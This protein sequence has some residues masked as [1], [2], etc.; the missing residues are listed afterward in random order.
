MIGKH[1]GTGPPLLFGGTGSHFVAASGRQ[2]LFLCLMHS[3]L[4]LPEQPELELDSTRPLT[5]Q[6]TMQSHSARIFLSSTF[7]DFH[8][9]RRLLVQEVFLALRERL[10]SRFVELVDVDLRWG[11]P[12]E[13]AESG[14]VLGICLDEVDQC[15]PYFIGLLGER[16]G[17]VPTTDKYPSYILESHPWLSEH[18][19]LASVTELEIRYGVLNNP[20]MR[21]RALFFFRDPAYAQSRGGEFL[22][23]SDEDADRQAYLK[24]QIKDS[25]LPVL[26]Y[27]TPEQLARMLEAELWKL[28]DA[29]F[30]ASD[31]PDAQELETLRHR[32][33]AA[34]KVGPKFVQDPALSRLLPDALAQGHQRILIT[35]AVGSGKSTL[36]ADWLRCAEED[37][38]GKNI[39]FH[40]VEADDESAT[41]ADLIGRIIELIR[42]RTGSVDPVPQDRSTLMKSLSIWLATAHAFAERTKSRWIIMLDALDGLR[43][44]RDLLWLPTFLPSTVQL[45]VSSRPGTLR[46]T[47]KRRG[48]WK[49]IQIEPLSR[50]RQKAMLAGQLA[51]FKKRLGEEQI[52]V[53]LAHPCADQ[54]L[55]L[56]VLAEELR[57]FGS[58]EGLQDHLNDLVSSPGIDDLYERIL[59]RLE[60]NGLDR[61]RLALSGICLSRGGMTEAEVLGF[62]GLAVQARWAPIRLA[63]GDALSNASGRV[64]P[65]HAHLRKAV[66]DRYYP[67]EQSERALRLELAS[68]FGQRPDSAIRASEQTHQLWKAAAYSDLLGQLSDPA[69]FK[70]V[71]RL[72][73]SSKLHQYWADIEANLEVSAKEHYQ[74]LWSQWRAELSLEKRLDLSERLQRFFRF[75][76][77]AGE[78][79]AQLAH[80][81]LRD[82]QD[83]YGSSDPLYLKHLGGCANTLAMYKNELENA[84][85]LAEQAC[86]AIE[87][88]AGSEAPELPPQLLDLAMICLKQR[89]IQPGIVAVRR[90]LLL[91]EALTDKDHPSLVEYLNCL[92]DLLLKGAGRARPGD[93]GRLKGGME[94]L[95]GIEL[96]TRCLRILG[97]TLG[98]EHLDSAASLVRVGHVFTRCLSV[99]HATRAYKRAQEIRVRLLGDRHPL[100]RSAARLL[101]R[102]S[103]I[104]GVNSA[105]DAL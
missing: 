37:Q 14:R 79:P 21:Q 74:S 31:V 75:R 20:A 102:S 94:L 97:R 34:F 3:A 76:A 69:I 53:A 35:G 26:H 58:F 5:R 88:V 22:P 11:I 33:Y 98:L 29:E 92:T 2:L 8:D 73:G 56:S 42:R 15:R 49:Y 40:F 7:R 96:Q 99:D 84:R 64:R 25:G 86:S 82:C 89:D 44:G 19:G 85:R 30:P 72:G 9:E 90:G 10:R 50:E 63:L 62:S 43:I 104:S 46:G 93:D 60:I 91:Q 41:P 28:L 87:R 18:H 27:Q 80:Q 52:A 59:K 17:W 77:L 100:T 55:F 101:E 95:E 105:S 32:S 51:V 16:Y 39:L 81:S 66:K 12:A 24:Q 38:H 54:A 103:G 1:F 48:A 70:L 45:V 65:S 71:D 23:E 47:L 78:F 83:L 61:I 4:P 6:A 36:I 67:D 57:V 68:W 13:E